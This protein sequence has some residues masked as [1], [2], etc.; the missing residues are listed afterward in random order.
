LLSGPPG[1]GK[2]LLARAI[3]RECGLPFV[4]ASGAEFS[5]SGPRSGSEKIFELFFTARANVRYDSYAFCALI[6]LVTCNL[7]IELRTGAGRE[8]KINL[9]AAKVPGFVCASSCTTVLV[10]GHVLENLRLW[11]CWDERNLK[12]SQLGNKT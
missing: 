5:E 6:Y 1:T 11:D 8:N 4:F 3:A 9:L 10:G 7:A 12:N 2:T